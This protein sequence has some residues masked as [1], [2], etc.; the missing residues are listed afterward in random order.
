MAQFA[1]AKQMIKQNLGDLPF[2]SVKGNHDITGPGAVDA[3]NRFMLPWMSAECGKPVDSASFYFMQGPDLFVIF[4]VY[5]H[6]DLNWLKKALKHNPHR[7]VFVVMHPPVVPCSARSAWH[8][9]SKPGELKKREV[10]LNILGRSKAIVLTAHLHKYSLLGRKTPKGTFVQFNMGS[11]ISFSP[12]TVED[13]VRG[14]ECYNGSLVELEPD[15]QPETIEL[16]KKILDDERD[17]VTFFECADF[18]GYAV[19]HV[20]DAAVAADIYAGDSSEKWKTV[21]LIQ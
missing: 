15:F 6:A 8:F 11:V 1:Y 16:R 9:L 19:F 21:N 5:H 10:L 17:S 3:Y 18:G 4:D 2:I 14:V 7:H 13:E 20:S 12:V